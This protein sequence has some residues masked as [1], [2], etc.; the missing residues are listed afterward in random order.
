MNSWFSGMTSDEIVREMS[1]LAHNAIAIAKQYGEAESD[2]M[3]KQFVKKFEEIIPS[4]VETKTAFYM[5]NKNIWN[6][7]DKCQSDLWDIRRGMETNIEEVLLH[8]V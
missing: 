1:R 7:W 5:Y 2:K 3:E 6:E 4:I 8:K